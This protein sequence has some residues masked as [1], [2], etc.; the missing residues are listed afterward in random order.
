MTG[1][2]RLREHGPHGPVFVRFGRDHPQSLW[3]AVG[4]PRRE[5]AEAKDRDEAR[6][7]QEEYQAQLRRAATAQATKKAAE[8]EVRR[9]VCTGCGARFT[10]ER[11]EAASATWPI[12][13]LP[14][15]GG[16]AGGNGGA[17]GFNS[18]GS[19]GKG[20]KAGNGG[21]G[22]SGG[23]YPGGAAGIGGVGGISNGGILNSGGN[24]GNGGN[25]GAKS[26]AS[27]DGACGIGGAG[28][29]ATG[30]LLFRG[31]AGGT[32]GTFGGGSPCANGANGTP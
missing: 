6:R 14:A 3:E 31:G 22:S 5:A 29:N 30:G 15:F 9:P 24:G 8:R 17:G 25:G 11:W 7:A 10:D 4:N 32:G 27:A 2:P 16:G 13:P 1:L 26:G 12:P 19:G 28:G 18:S 20:G 23:A 21:N